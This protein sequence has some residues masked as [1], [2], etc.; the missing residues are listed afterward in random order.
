MNN[1]FGRKNILYLLFLFVF[2]LVAL[3]IFARIYLASLEK[4]PNPKFRFNAYRLYEHVPGF[5]EG[6]NHADWIKI[7]NQG[8]RRSNDV[9]RQKPANTVRIFL[10][11]GSAAH[12][13]STAKPYPRMHIYMDQTI[14]AFLERKL[15]KTYP[16]K[17]IEVINA[18]V[19][20]YQCF[21]HTAYIL[22]ELIDYS[23]D[24]IIFFDGA[25]D[26]FL[27]NPV[28]DYYKQNKYQFW[29]PRLQQPS[30]GGLVNYKMMWL[31]RY[32]AFARGYFSW[33]LN[34]D[35]LKREKLFMPTIDNEDKNKIIAGHREN[36]RKGFL[37]SVETNINILKANNIKCMVCLQPMLRLRN[38]ENLSAAEKNIYNLRDDSMAE[39]LYPVVLD[40]LKLLTAKYNVPFLDINPAFNKECFRGQQLLLDYCHLSAAGGFVA[41][42]AIFPVADS[43]I[44]K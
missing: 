6:N 29:T 44:R 33:K 8:F 37:R 18:A 7:N 4:S 35:A 24:L 10:L 19:T 40:E 42:N 15:K 23:P 39:V 27:N 36:A 16:E 41:A 14:D 17:N 9:S 13:I 20:G 25:N 32:S 31:A 5:T 22:S 21:Q 1:I 3:E 2:T 28:Y 12:G 11:G 30:F 38:N 34:N 26:H 43:L